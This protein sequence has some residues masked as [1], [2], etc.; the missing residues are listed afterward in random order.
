MYYWFAALYA[1]PLLHS[2]L[3]FDRFSLAM[4]LTGAAHMQVQRAA[5]CG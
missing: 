3:E 4:L 5:L 2:G 1:L